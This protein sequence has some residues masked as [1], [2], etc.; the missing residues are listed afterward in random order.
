M[1]RPIIKPIGTPVEALDTPALVVDMDALEANIERVHVRFRDSSVSLRPDVETH[2]CPAIARMQI[3]AG[4]TNGG[5]AVAS[6]SEAEMFAQNGISDF[7][8]VH[9]V[10]TAPKIARLCALARQASVTV[11]VD[12]AANVSALS[13]AAQGAGVTLKVVL[14]INTGQERSGVAP[15]EPALALARIVS[16][17]E[18]L[19]LSGLMSSEDDDFGEDMDSLIEKS[20]HRIQQTLDTREMLE[21]DGI[22]VETVCVSAQQPMLAGEV[23]GVTEVLNGVYALMDVRHS[24]MLPELELAAK[25]LASVTSLPEPGTAIL[26]TGRKAMGDDYG[27]PIIEGRGELDVSSMSAEHGK[28]QWDDNSDVGLSLGDRIRFTPMDIG[29]TVNV[30]DYIQAVRGGNLEAVLAISARGLYR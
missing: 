13:D 8:I 26:D 20:S 11:A 2:R 25:V 16:R 12:N 4:G 19:N 17:S 22:A 24:A 7:L 14:D 5:V 18:S 28:L 6:V 15:G 21:R 29:A 1:E 3:A 27:F 23:D 9:E 10:V 30:Y